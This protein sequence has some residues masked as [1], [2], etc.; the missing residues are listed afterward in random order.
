MYKV[1]SGRERTC[2][3]IFKSLVYLTFLNLFPNHQPCAYY[4]QFNDIIQ[5]IIKEIFSPTFTV[6]K[7]LMRL[8][9]IFSPMFTVRKLLVRLSRSR[10]TYQKIFKGILL[11]PQTRLHHPSCSLNYSRTSGLR[12]L[13]NLQLLFQ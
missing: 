4:L 12:Q 13:S 6:M 7:L 11:A 1:I 10:K 3:C 8:S 5:S 9:R 2:R